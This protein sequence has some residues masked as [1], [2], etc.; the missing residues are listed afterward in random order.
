M[1]R[2][3]DL[4]VV[5]QICQQQ[6]ELNEVVPA[7]L[8]PSQVVET[9]LKEYA[10]VIENAQGV[11]RGVFLSHLM[12]RCYQAVLR[13]ASSP[14]TAPHT[15]FALSFGRKLLLVFQEEHE[16]GGL[17]LNGLVSWRAVVLACYYSND[18]LQCRL[19]ISSF[20]SLLWV[21]SQ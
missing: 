6:K 4:T 3:Q 20:C 7:E 19:L 13:L 5:C 9:M 15:M 11:T 12:V 14:T 21:G 16:E 8:V 10:I 18:L 1:N 2:R 17:C